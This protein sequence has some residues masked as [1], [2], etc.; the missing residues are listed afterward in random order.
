[1]IRLK[2][3]FK[4]NG[5]SY[6]QLWRNDSNALYQGSYDRADGK[7]GYFY[8]VFKVTTQKKGGF[9]TDDWER[10]PSDEMF[11]VTAWC[12]ESIES[13]LKQVHKHFQDADLERF[14]QGL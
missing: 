8:E 2:T 11:G 4:K 12:C 3:E 14:V 10:Y 7:K 13:L 1:M 6:Q 9:H 5:N